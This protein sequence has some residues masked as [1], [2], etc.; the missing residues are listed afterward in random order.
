MRLGDLIIAEWSHNGAM[1]F[2]E[3]SAEEAPDFHV[4]EY[5]GH[6]LRQRS[7]KVKVGNELKDAITHHENGQWMTWASNAIRYHTGVS[8]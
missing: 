8:V 4:P 5:L 6:Q 1:R 2:W 3:A 7:L